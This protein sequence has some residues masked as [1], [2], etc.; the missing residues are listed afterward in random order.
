MAKW[1]SRVFS[2]PV[3]GLFGI[4]LTAL[5]INSSGVWPWTGYYILLTILIP[6]VYIVYKVRKGDITDF[7]MRV[8]KQ[9]IR[10]MA[11][12][13]GC[14]SFAWLSMWAGSAPKILIIFAGA[15]VF[16]ITFFLL[17]SL[18][19]KISGHGTAIANLAVF[20]WALFG[21]SATPAVIAVPVVMWARVRLD[22]HSI[23]QT[24][25]GTIAGAAFMLVLLLIVSSNC[26]GLTLRCE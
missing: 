26:Q 4:S 23:A 5:A 14:T 17:V 15:G 13:L 18:R 10:P 19:W 3:L 2:P 1:V 21:A 8:R 11:L 20:L 6:L 9:R 22:R 24:I 12:T 7:H 16:Q 25:A